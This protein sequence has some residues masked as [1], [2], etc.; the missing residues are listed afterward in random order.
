MLKLEKQVV[1]WQMPHGK[2]GPGGPDCSSRPR[3]CLIHRVSWSRAG[4]GQGAG[5][6]GRQEKVSAMGARGEACA[7]LHAQDRGEGEAW[8]DLGRSDYL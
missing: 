2:A 6:L 3:L 8:D 5:P 7:T 1:R 4:K